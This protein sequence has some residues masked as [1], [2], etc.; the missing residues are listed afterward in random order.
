M[1]DFVKKRGRAVVN[2]SHNN[3]N[4]ASGDKLVLFVISVVDKT[5]LDCN[6]NLFFYLCAELFRYKTCGIKVNGCVNSRHNSESHKLLD[7]LRGGYL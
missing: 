5:L 2:M 1:S 4:R 7:N 3:D 6:N